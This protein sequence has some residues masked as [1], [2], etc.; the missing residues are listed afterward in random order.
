M[1]DNK[2]HI[3][4]GNAITLFDFIEKKMH[5]ISIIAVYVIFKFI[6]K[7]NRLRK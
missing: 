7:S 3:T 6:D 5:N 2:F 1:S 4:N